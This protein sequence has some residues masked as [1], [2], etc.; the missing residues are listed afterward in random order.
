MTR[1]G[2]EPGKQVT[3]LSRRGKVKG[4]GTRFAMVKRK[5][6]EQ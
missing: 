3:S 4:L 5:F 2:K 1:E 6:L